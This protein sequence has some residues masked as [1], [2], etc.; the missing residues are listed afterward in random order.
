MRELRGGLW[1]SFGRSQQTKCKNTVAQRINMRRTFLRYFSRDTHTNVMC[2]ELLSTVKDH[3]QSWVW[4][5]AWPLS[6]TLE[7]KE[8]IH[9]WTPTLPN[10][11]PELPRHIHG[12][13]VAYFSKTSTLGWGGSSRNTM[14]CSFNDHSSNNVYWASLH[15]RHK[16]RH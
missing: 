11:I 8:A 7:Q 1:K 4:I 13:K 10:P 15:T 5:S 12:R 2:K 16:C 9:E 14:K 6:Q 3:S